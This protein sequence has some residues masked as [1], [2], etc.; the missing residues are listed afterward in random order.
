MRDYV[1]KTLAGEHDELLVYRKR[2][3]HRL[4]EY[5]VNVPPQ[6][7]AARLADEFNKAQG[8]PLR[9]QNGGRIS[10][11]V[12]TNGPE[13]LEVQRSPIDYQHYLDKQ[14]Q[15]IAD[16]ILLPLQDSFA[17]LTTAQQAL[18]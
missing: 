3:R 1:R 17:A 15:P 4:D 13:P 5:Q 12:T 16:A 2:L 7:R 11:V 18:F 10:Y 9:Y 8:R 6:V 14:L